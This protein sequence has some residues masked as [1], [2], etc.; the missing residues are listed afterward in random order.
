VQTTPVAEKSFAGIGHVLYR[1]PNGA[2]Q[3]TRLTTVASRADK[4]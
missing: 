1:A 4:P 3:F 2:V